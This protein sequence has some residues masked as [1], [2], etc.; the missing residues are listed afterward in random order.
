MPDEVAA[1][2]GLYQQTADVDYD[3]VNAVVT[4]EL[5][6]R[7]ERVVHDAGVLEICHRTHDPEHYGDKPQG[8]RHF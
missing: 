5:V 7:G 4:R 2:E 8:D 6:F 1:Q 3:G